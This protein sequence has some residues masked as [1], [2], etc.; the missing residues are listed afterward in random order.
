MGLGLD[1]IDM[2]LLASAKLAT[3]PLWTLD[4]PLRTVATHL[5]V[6]WQNWREVD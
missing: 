1:Y 4:R 6:A 3:L 5:N 2:Y